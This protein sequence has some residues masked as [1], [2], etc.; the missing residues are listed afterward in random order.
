MPPRAAENRVGILRRGW[1]ALMVLADRLFGALSTTVLL[2]VIATTPVLQFFALGYLLTAAARLAK[3]GKLREG[4]VGVQEASRLGQILL[5]GWLVT[6]PY[7]WATGFW[8]DAMLIAPG[9][10]QVQRMANLRTASA[11][12]AIWVIVAALSQ[13]GALVHFLRPLRA[14]LRLATQMRELGG[15]RFAER[16]ARAARDFLL[17]FAPLEVFSLGLRGYLGA[18]LL[19]A[20]PTTVIAIGRGKGP[21]VVV[22]GV[23][24]VALLLYLPFLQI[25]FAVHNELKRV[26][27]VRAV[28]FLFKRAPLAFFLALLS[29]LLLALPL[30]LLKIELVPRE[31][32]W[33][34]AMVFVLTV[35]PTKIITAWAYQRAVRRDEPRHVVWQWLARLLMV[36]VATI[37]AV[38]VFLTQYTGWHG[39]LGLYEHH[40]FLLPVPF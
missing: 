25:H 29:T 8:V 6:I 13:G 38:A 34:P 16:A 10:K 35:F 15:Y 14:T 11:A 4:F 3:T 37:Y 23:M 22:G 7:R 17:G 18:G 5:G 1:L 40:A 30:Y 28:R 31:A 33:L 20:V 39:V 21:L 24:L 19:L 36:P 27:D 12:F 2:A 26:V 9:S 32:L